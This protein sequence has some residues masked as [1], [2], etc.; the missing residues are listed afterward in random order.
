MLR[1]LVG[2]AVD[3]VSIETIAAGIL[4]RIWH[5]TIISAPAGD[6]GKLDNETIAEAA[7]WNLDADRLVAILVDVGWL[8]RCETNRLVIH[9]WHEHAP[10]FVK[11]N[12][13]KWGKPFASSQPLKNTKPN[14]TKPNLTGKQRAKHI[15]RQPAKQ[16]FVP[17]DFDQVSEYV[18]QYQAEQRAD[19]KTW[20]VRKFDVQQFL[21][22]Y[23]ANG[24][25]QAN[26][27]RLKCWKATVRNWG[28][29][30]FGGKRQDG[31]RAEQLYR[32]MDPQASSGGIA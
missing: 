28:R 8:D 3:V 25:K 18:S 16:K 14:L 1:P 11:G 5:L 24:W 2:N 27:N 9:D 12:L 29:R 7:G 22:H 20:P 32:N 31:Q 4:E 23:E 10:S 26:G 6:I 15:A 17:P 13:S 21:D 19:G 30:D